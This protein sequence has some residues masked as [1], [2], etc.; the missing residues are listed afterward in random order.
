MPK[1]LVRADFEIMTDPAARS[2]ALT[3][4]RRAEADLVTAKELGASPSAIAT[5]SKVRAAADDRLRSIRLRGDLRSASRPSSAS[6]AAGH[7]PA[8]RSQ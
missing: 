4:S 2:Q 6:V 8:R 1:G 3:D 5:L 7:L